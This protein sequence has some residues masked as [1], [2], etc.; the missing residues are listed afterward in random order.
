MVTYTRAGRTRA[1]SPC[2]V[3]A[4]AAVLNVAELIS[5]TFSV[6]ATRKCDRRTRCPSSV[7]GKWVAA[8]CQQ[9]CV[10]THTQIACTI[11]SELSFVIIL[12]DCISRMRDWN[13]II[14]ITHAI[15]TR[16]LQP[17]ARFTENPTVI[18]VHAP[19]RT[20]THFR[21]TWMQSCTRRHLC[22]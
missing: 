8:A 3:F 16:A 7:I 9:M 10:R 1:T 18:L 21:L 19:A 12:R 4:L 5:L 11:Y 15:H 13:S 17:L 6:S 22:G 2:S 14:P 20:H